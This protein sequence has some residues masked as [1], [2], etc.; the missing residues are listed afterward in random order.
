MV[1]LDAE[2]DEIK[3]VI[4]DQR[5]GGVD[6]L[7]VGQYLQPSKKHYSI[8]RYYMMEEFAALCAPMALQSGLPMGGSQP[9]DALVAPCL[10]AGAR[11]ERRIS[12]IVWK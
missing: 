2:I 6:I 8:S 11:P 10:R 1:G 9:A 4:C 12:R 3:A 7:T 5:N